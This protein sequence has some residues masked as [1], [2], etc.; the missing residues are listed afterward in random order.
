VLTLIAG[1]VSLETSPVTR[2]LEEVTLESSV[3][4]LVSYWSLSEL[5]CSL[6]SL[7]R[8]HGRFTVNVWFSS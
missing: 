5:E 1:P 4:S 3:L 8:S 2:K 7:Q 6:S